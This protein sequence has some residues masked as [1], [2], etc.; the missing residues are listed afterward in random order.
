MTTWQLLSPN[1]AALAAIRRTP[2]TR[3]APLPHSGRKGHRTCLSVS[4]NWE[5][6]SLKVGCHAISCGVMDWTKKCSELVI[7][8]VHIIESTS[9]Q[10]KQMAFLPR[11]TSYQ[12]RRDDWISAMYQYKGA[13]SSRE[14]CLLTVFSLSKTSLSSWKLKWVGQGLQLATMPTG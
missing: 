8:S 12:L 7:I 14:T 4:Q 11:V 6:N 5:N 9:N 13:I 10:S 2:S 1:L 3:L